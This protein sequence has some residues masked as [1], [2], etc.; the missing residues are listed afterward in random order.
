MRALL[1]AMDKEMGPPFTRGRGLDNPAG[2]RLAQLQEDLVVCQCGVGKVNAALAVQY[3]LDRF[4]VAELW[5][6]GV[7][8]CFHP[9][10][11]GTLVMVTACVQ[12][13]LDVFGDPPGQVPVLEQVFLPCA[14][15]QRW[16][17]QLAAA[18][19]P[20]RTGV[21]A[22]GDWFGRDPRRA[23]RIQN[24]F[25]PLVCDMEAG[26]A[27][28][29]CLRNQIPFHCLKAVSDHLEHPGQYQQYQDNLPRAVEAL[30]RALAVL[31][32]LGQ[33]G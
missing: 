15:P 29:V 2:L 11:A 21:A 28:Q 16:A 26:A 9:L 30:N 31:L 5:N 1:L 25:H 7:A 4:P 27:A 20:C 8:G 17:Q 6:A 33:A 10:P 32:G 13:D 12:H 24:Q 23:Q 14:C 19:F 18:G 22:T 3:L